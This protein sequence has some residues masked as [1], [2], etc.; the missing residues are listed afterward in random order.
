MAP[1]TAAGASPPPPVW[2][3]GG[4]TPAPQGRTPAPIDTTGKQYGQRTLDMAVEAAETR[5]R[6]AGAAA[7]A[8]GQADIARLQEAQKRSRTIMVALGSMVVL[9]L[10]V[11]CLLGA[12][13]AYV[14]FRH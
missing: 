12:A 5:G 14:L 4:A 13:L 11:S 8:G 1:A 10:G 9:L 6:V 7:G 3:G 2:T